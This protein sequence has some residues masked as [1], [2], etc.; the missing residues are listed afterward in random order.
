MADQKKDRW[1][2]VFCPDDACMTEAERFSPPAS[3]NAAESDEWLELFCP[4][5]SCEI[6]SP[7][8]VP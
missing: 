1:L 7:T 2:K 6:T 5:G 4:E 8:Q 3:E